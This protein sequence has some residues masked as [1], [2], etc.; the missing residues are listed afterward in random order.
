MAGPL[1]LLA[2][3]FR[4]SAPRADCHRFAAAV[5]HAAD[6]QL[7]DSDG[8]TFLGTLQAS[9]ADA[10]A[11]ATYLLD[12][13]TAGMVASLATIESELLA[14]AVRSRR[15]RLI[16]DFRRL[17]DA[18]QPGTIVLPP[19]M[20]LD[21]GVA[22]FEPA[23]VTLSSDHGERRLPAALPDLRGWIARLNSMLLDRDSETSSAERR[24][25]IWIDERP[26]GFIKP[27]RAGETYTLCC[28]AG[29]P[30]LAS[31]NT[32]ASTRLNDVPQGGLQTEWILVSR[33]VE[34]IPAEPEVVVEVIEQAGQ[35]V[36]LA[37]FA[38]SI[39]EEDDSATRT[40]KIT[41]HSR[42]DAC[43]SVM[44]DAV[45]APERRRHYRSFSL[46]LEVANAE[47]AAS[48]QLQ[49]ENVAISGR[50]AGNVPHAWHGTSSSL[51][52]MPRQGVAIV[53]GTV[54][55][56]QVRLTETHWPANQAIHSAIDGVVTAAEAFRLSES[57]SPDRLNDIDRD[58]LLHSLADFEFIHRWSDVPDLAD[59]K[60]R[61][62][63]ETT[64]QS[65]ALRNLADAGYSLYQTFFP[66]GSGLRTELDRL[67]PGDPLE[68]FWSERD[69]STPHVPWGLMFRHSNPGK[70]IDPTGFLGLHL[71]ITYIAYASR[72]GETT[73]GTVPKSKAGA[74]LY[75]G[76]DEIGDEA[77][78]Q[79]S[80]WMKPRMI[81]RVFSSRPHG[82]WLR[83]PMPEPLPVLYFY[84]R[85]ATATAGSEPVL[86]FG[87]ESSAQVGLADLGWS[88]LPSAPLVFAN[89][90]ATTASDPE[91]VNAFEQRFF[92]RHCRA[93]IGTEC[94]VGVRLASRFA[95]V[96]HDLFERKRD[97]RTI[98][99]G[100]AV[101][102]A[103]L[104][105]WSHYR[106]LGGLFYSIIN[107][108][109][110]YLADESPAMANVS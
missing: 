77:E 98:T 62:A 50:L 51:S 96:F 97:G 15:R 65:N 57:G 88:K 1:V 26:A 103:R 107:Q 110:L 30:L 63:W 86:L 106:N 3:Q 32:D 29:K 80:I 48:L 47:P 59:A 60:H 72:N 33:N 92:E 84:C 7:L 16:H 104:F 54:N 56:R 81:S 6:G 87:D 94:R 27:L 46:Q 35:T 5:Y 74:A 66:E 79:R 69:T 24:L 28:N 83:N 31:I 61:E 78:W 55:G 67:E 19:S 13:T 101:S 21:E 12:R 41:P 42:D 93:Y 10:M 4:D 34:L 68:V 45:V 109:E 25:N 91:R 64:A 82:E 23:A 8:D 73:L 105:L 2:I 108:S 9:P 76:E 52:V 49:S 102:Q 75:A 14:R 20:P 36:W 85:T 11:M 58:D 95:C 40:I 18:A 90:C 100:E 39:P 71:R 70:R 53:S 99:A 43:I 17:L 37:R 38:L 89:A 22:D 44:I